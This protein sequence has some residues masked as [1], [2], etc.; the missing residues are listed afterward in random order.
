MKRACLAAHPP[1]RIS[2]ST[3]QYGSRAERAFSGPESILLSASQSHRR[4]RTICAKNQTPSGPFPILRH[5][6]AL[7]PSDPTTMSLNHLFHLMS[8]PWDNRARSFDRCNH[9]KFAVLILLITSLGRP[10]WERVVVDW[11]R[12]STVLGSTWAD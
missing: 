2:P 6:A 3:L 10:H 5:T 9:W 1:G 11:L 12:G 4:S 7:P 8:R